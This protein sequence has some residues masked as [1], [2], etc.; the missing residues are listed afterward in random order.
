MALTNEQLEILINQKYSEL[1]TRMSTLQG[2]RLSP[3]QM[4]ADLEKQGQLIRSISKIIA[5]LD[6]DVRTR[7][8]VSD[9][10]TMY[11]E[12]S[13]LVKDNSS[14]IQQLETKL[15]KIILPDQTKYYLEEGEVA[16]FKSNFARLNA[17]MSKFEKL[18]SNLVA[19]TAMNTK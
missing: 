18:Y 19:Y 7:P 13:K 6:Q 8:M 9:I 12:L 3:R 11:K 15:A 4:Q 5:E 1:D 17:M 16:D 2:G 10:N 14:I